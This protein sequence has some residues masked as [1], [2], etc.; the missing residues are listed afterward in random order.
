MLRKTLSILLLAP[1]IALAGYVSTTVPAGRSR[2]GA[3]GRLVAWQAAGTNATASLSLS[4]V[5]TVP[6]WRDET[7]YSS[8]AAWV[9]TSLATN[10]VPMPYGTNY[11]VTVAS[12]NQVWTVATNTVAVHYADL[13]QTNQ[14]ASVTL[15]G[16]FASGTADAGVFLFGGDLL[17]TGGTAGSELTIVLEE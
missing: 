9:A 7:T 3:E 6:L 4:H 12:S 2:L 5:R 1:C 17:L 14:V 16:G 8:N 15:S 13:E 11:V 10:A